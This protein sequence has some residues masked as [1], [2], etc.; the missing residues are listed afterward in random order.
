M[1]RKIIPALIGI[2]VL[3]GA[4]TAIAF[5]STLNEGAI[6]LPDESYL[7]DEETDSNS[8][9]EERY[10]ESMEK[11]VENTFAGIEKITNVNAC[12]NYD[13]DTN[14]YSIDLELTT[15]EGVSEGDVELYK[16]YLDKTFSMITLTI[17]GRVI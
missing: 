9:K 4:T 17:D 12:V 10:I 14:Q 3:G 16:S 13:N 5:A 2:V 6:Y 1:K 8:A 7:I 15:D 11:E